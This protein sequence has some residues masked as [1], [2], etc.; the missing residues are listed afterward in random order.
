MAALLSVQITAPVTAVVGPQLEF[1]AGPSL[2]LSVLVQGKFSYGSGGTT[3]TAWVQ[4]SC[5][6]GS[7]WADVASFGYTTLSA[8]SLYNLSALTVGT[9]A[10]VPTDGTMASNTS[11]D[12]II[13]SQWRVKYTTT[14]TY[15]GTTLEVDLGA[16][17]LTQ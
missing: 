7:T 1:R 15:V 11:K 9:T 4:T 2:P 16:P 13:G 10:Y 14:G 3:V 12:G 17:G 6:G 5:D 8:R